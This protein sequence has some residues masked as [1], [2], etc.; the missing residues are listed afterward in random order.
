VNDDFFVVLSKVPLPKAKYSY[1]DSL[2]L[3][4][5]RAN[6]DFELGKFTK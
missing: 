1:K 5:M 3:T 2:S 4:R 6:T